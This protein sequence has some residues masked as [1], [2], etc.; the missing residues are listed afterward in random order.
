MCI[1]VVYGGGTIQRNGLEMMGF[2]RFSDFAV[3]GVDEKSPLVFQREYTMIQDRLRNPAEGSYTAKLASDPNNAFKKM[4]E[5]FAEFLGALKG[6]KTEE[7][8]QNVVGE[9]QDLMYTL[10]LNMAMR[11]VEFRDITRG[12]YRR[13]KRR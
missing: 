4:G 1:E 11:G 10:Q 8:R 6:C 2:V 12:M 9:F 3:I 7:D 13:L 5:E